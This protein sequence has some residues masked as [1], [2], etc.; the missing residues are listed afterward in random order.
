VGGEGPYKINLVPRDGFSDLFRLISMAKV[1]THKLAQARALRKNETAAEQ[2]LWA[3]LRAKRL[4]GFKFVRQL[5]VGPYIVD[6]ACRSQNLI[7][8]VDGATHGSVAEIE[9]DQRRTAFLE[10]EGW[11][12]LR[13]GNDAVFNNL[14]GVCDTI[15]LAFEK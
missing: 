12:V 10:S 2:R 3:C 1:D 14:N 4:N 15:L 11:R 8:E 7:V 9:Y 13:V 6:L 5:V